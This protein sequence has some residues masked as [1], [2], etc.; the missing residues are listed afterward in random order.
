MRLQSRL[1]TRHI[2][3]L[4]PPACTIT[5]FPSISARDRIIDDCHDCMT[6]LRLRLPLAVSFSSYFMIKWAAHDDVA[7]VS[8]C[9]LNSFYPFLL[10]TFFPHTCYVTTPG[11]SG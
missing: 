6:I 4:F 9:G 8:L 1:V 3:A 5:E 11:G 2:R 7:D 10:P